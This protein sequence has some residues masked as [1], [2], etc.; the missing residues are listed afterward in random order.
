MLYAFGIFRLHEREAMALL[1]RYPNLD[2]EALQEKYPN[3]DINKLLLN[4]KTLGNHEFN[5][6]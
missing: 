6:A 5:T 2:K 4:K 3:I 1:K